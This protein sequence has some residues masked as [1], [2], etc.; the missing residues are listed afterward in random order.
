MYNT[1]WRTFLLEC[2]CLSFWLSFGI[3]IKMFFKTYVSWI[4]LY[5]NMDPLLAWGVHKGMIQWDKYLNL[6]KRKRKSKAEKKVTT[7]CRRRRR[8]AFPL[9]R[10]RHY[11]LN[12]LNSIYRK[13]KRRLWQIFL[14]NTHNRVYHWLHT[15]AVMWC[16]IHDKV[17]QF[18]ISKNGRHFTKYE[19]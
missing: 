4:Y 16:P 11:Y 9:S 6:T 8:Q 10:A 13:T 12:N 19:V 14:K 3:K 18:L 2:F 7:G 15:T 17:M 5:Q 1:C